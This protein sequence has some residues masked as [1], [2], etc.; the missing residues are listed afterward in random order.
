MLK[1]EPTT[2]LRVYLIKPSRYDDAGY[3]VRHWKGVIPSNTLSTLNGL[4]RAVA[5]SAALGN[6]KLDSVL[7]DESVQ[8]IPYA[9]I[10]RDAR[11]MRVVI[12]LAGVQ[13][14]QFP[15]AADLAAR[16]RKLG[17]DV[18]IGGFHVSGV[19][20]LLPGRSPEVQ[21]LVDIGVHV[22]RGEVDARWG[23]I[24]TL[25]LNGTL[26]TWFDL[27]TEQPDL[28]RL[29]LPVTDGH[30][31][32]RF[33]V[34][35]LGTIDA[36]RGCP[37]NC[38]FCTI[39]N[40]QGRKM[41]ARTP[42][43]ILKGMREQYSRG[44][45]HYFF[46]DD[47]FARHPQWE[48]ILDGMAAMRAEGFKLTCMMQLDTQAVRIPNFVSKAQAAGCSQVFIGLESINPDNLAAAGKRQNR[49]EDFKSMVDTW[50]AHDINAQCGYILGFP[51]DTPASIKSDVQ[52]L[53]DEIGMDIA[54]F[55]ILM[56]LPGSA[57]HAKAVRE[58]VVIDPDLNNFDSTHVLVEHP[59]MSRA[60]LMQAYRE[61]WDDFYSVDHMK[62]ALGKLD[63]YRYWALFEMFMWYRNSAL[64]GEHPMA[65]GFWRKRDRKERRPGFKRPNVFAHTLNRLRYTAR[66]LK[67]WYRLL[68]EMQEVWL[69]TRKP[70]PTEGRVA[71]IAKSALSFRPS[72][73]LA[74][75]TA[76]FHRWKN[77]RQDLNAF[78]KGL[79]HMRW[80]R[81]NPLIAPWKAFR[82]WALM[83]HFLLQLYI[84]S[85]KESRAGLVPTV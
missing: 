62:R 46:T 11:R 20:A 83:T 7:V 72:V 21:Q 74:N 3:V 68:P 34:S 50:H 49:V 64:L 77:T 80:L 66:Q 65:S 36:S 47:N 75:F 54:S 43:A 33:A 71:A 70:D 42:Q 41:R 48:E 59:N 30:Y 85:V 84:E 37:F 22:V 82:E 26:P 81:A 44:V 38:S 10:R 25:L 15:R 58:G 73:A 13:S 14:N 79:K 18:L 16:F 6:T 69:A 19:N 2:H 1:T 29:P 56:P 61:A 23:E 35:D 12:A 52:R 24:L 45:R 76:R 4:N 31:M 17:L 51:H 78:W 55:F 53:R 40:V 5:E 8:K 67:A 27:L 57:D 39:V 32:H 28:S 60:E 9:R 63:G